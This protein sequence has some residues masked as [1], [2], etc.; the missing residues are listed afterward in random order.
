MNSPLVLLPMTKTDLDAV[1]LHE[2][3]VY[4]FPWTRGNF[5]DSLQAGHGCWVAREQGALAAYAVMMQILDEAH[6]LNITVLPAL[7]QQGRGSAL[8]GQ[9]FAQ[10]RGQ[11]A[12]RVFLEVRRSNVAAQRLYLRHEFIRIGERRGYYPAHEGREDAIVMARDL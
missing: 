6:L 4:P 1:V 11:G 2:A 3:Q 12:L 5:Q 10:V 9:L 8:L 7:Q